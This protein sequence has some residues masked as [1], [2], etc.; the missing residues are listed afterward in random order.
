MDVVTP[1]TYGCTMTGRPDHEGI[2]MTNVQRHSLR[3]MDGIRDHGATRF[4]ESARDVFYAQSISFSHARNTFA[5]RLFCLSHLCHNITIFPIHTQRQDVRTVSL[6]QI[7]MIKCSVCQDKKKN[8]VITK[9][10]HM[11][12]DGCLEKSIKV[13]ASR[14]IMKNTRRGPVFCGMVVS[15]VAIYLRRDVIA[16]KPT[17]MEASGAT[18]DAVVVNMEVYVVVAHVGRRCVSE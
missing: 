13:R 6:G 12:C 11:F 2:A 1:V 5:T 7:Q 14:V 10:F 9:C 17:D 3:V 8:R 4:D 16:S 15:I 18:V